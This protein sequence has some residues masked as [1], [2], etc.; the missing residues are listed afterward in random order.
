ML[1]PKPIFVLVFTE[2]YN[3]YNKNEGTYNMYIQLL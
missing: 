2:G 1:R 3:T